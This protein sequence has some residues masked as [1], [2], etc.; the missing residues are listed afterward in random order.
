MT[1]WG[2]IKKGDTRP[3]GDVLVARITGDDAEDRLAAAIWGEEP[4]RRTIVTIAHWHK[5]RSK[6]VHGPRGEEVRGV[7]AWMHLPE[8]PEENSE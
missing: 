8:P 7:Y 1:G 6:W 4:E 3:V 5:G 2:Y